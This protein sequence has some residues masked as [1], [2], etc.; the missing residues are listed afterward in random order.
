LEA[1]KQHW[2]KQQ[3]QQQ[4]RYEVHVFF[5]PFVQKLAKSYPQKSLFVAEIS[6]F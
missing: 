6:G 1:S 4:Q 5:R 3:Q 2:R